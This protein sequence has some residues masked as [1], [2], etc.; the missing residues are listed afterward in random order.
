MTNAAG[1]SL[2]NDQKT[3]RAW[4]MY[5]WANSVYSL[6]ITSSIFPIYY[7]AVARADDTEMVS[8]LG[9]TL[10][11]SNLY[12]YALS[13]SFL[14]VALMLPLLSGMADYSGKKKTFMKSFVWL[15]SLSCIG[16]YF[17]TGLDTLWIGL[18]C[19]ITASIGYSGSLVFYDA[20]LPEV[21]SEDRYDARE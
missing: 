1:G 13:F 21:V 11:N 2:L 17:F 5:D 10:Q 12:S 18:L 3:V 14:I 6:V 20:F 16:L 4:Y 15:G 8:F 19:S 9:F 7:K